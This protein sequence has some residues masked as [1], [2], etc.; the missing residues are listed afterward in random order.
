MTFATALK[1]RKKIVQSSFYFYQLM[2][3][4]DRSPSYKKHAIVI[5]MLMLR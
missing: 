5:N 1:K 3:M 4:K 2:I